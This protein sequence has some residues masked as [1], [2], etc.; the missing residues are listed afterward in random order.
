MTLITI[1]PGDIEE[2]HGSGVPAFARL[3]ANQQFTSSE[4]ILVA[5]GS[6]G[7]HRDFFQE[8]VAQPFEDKVHLSAGDAYSTTNSNVP[9]ATYS[10]VVYDAKGRILYTPYHNLRIPDENNPTTWA[11][12]EEFSKA[13]TLRYPPTYLNAEAQLRLFESFGREAGWGSVIGDITDQTDLMLVLQGITAGIEADLALKENADPDLTAIAQLAPTNDDILQRKGDVWTNRTPSQLKADLNLGYFSASDYDSLEDAIDDID[14]KPAELKITEETAVNVDVAIPATT[15]LSFAGE[16]MLVVEAGCTVTI[17]LMTDPGNKQIF[18]L[19]DA[20]ANIRFAN[21]AVERFN[22]AWWAGPGVGVD[23]TKAINDMIASSALQG[24]ICKFYFPQ[25]TSVT[26]GG[27]V[28]GSATRIFGNS[29]HSNAA[30]G[31][32][33]T[34]R[35]KPG[36]SAPFMFKIGP[37]KNNIDFSEI[38]LD[39]NGNATVCIL[40]EGSGSESAAIGTS[41]TRV[42]FSGF[43]KQVHHHST[44]GAWQ[45]AQVSFYRCQFG[46]FSGSAFAANS[47]NGQFHFN[48]CYFAPLPGAIDFDLAGAGIMGIENSEFAGSSYI[49]TFQ[50]ADIDVASNT[51]NK[52]AHGFTGNEPVVVISSGGLPGTAPAGE[53]STLCFIKYVD[54]SHIQFSKVAG[55][56]AIDLTSQGTGTHSIYWASAKVM[57]VTGAH[58]A[59]TFSNCQEE[60]HG[61]ML[62]N[63]ASDISGIFNFVNGC[64]IQSK[65]KSDASCQINIDRCNLFSYAVQGS[66][67]F[68][69]ITDCNIR[70]LSVNDGLTVVSPPV[71]SSGA[72]TVLSERNSI[73]GYHTLRIPQRDIST[74]LDV[75]NPAP[76]RSI[77]HIPNGSSTRK[78]LLR[79]GRMTN[80]EVFDFYYSLGRDNTNGRFFIE[81]NQAEPFRGFDFNADVRATQL[82]MS[83]SVA[84]ATTSPSVMAC[85]AANRFTITPNANVTIDTFE[86]VAGKHY[87]LT[88]LTAGVTSY[89]ITFGAGF[90]STGVLATGVVAGKYFVVE[91]FA[92]DATTLLELRRTAAL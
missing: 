50:P 35:L 64:L 58:G 33:T 6:R 37:T 42:T 14:D 30:V 89:D 52:P 43:T 29:Y 3:Y 54:P 16:G 79:L 83:T 20:T 73:L 69:N 26:E 12:L 36:T 38:I 46:L 53:F 19:E 61:A 72:I 66:A 92:P 13:V 2:Y 91:F 75:D 49:V 34:L 65:I 25:L 7:R 17:G 47:V 40:A 11:T 31:F 23:V 1:G 51:V 28:L 10:L 18:A 45:W 59:I 84:L 44:S 87:Y 82:S 48:D 71:V 41:F 74:A 81:G 15:L 4:G 24:G 39:A 22:A 63:T 90:K 21:G 77:G 56:S 60:G 57:R 27:H 86:I 76:V 80:A 8:F 70:P 55:G 67:G 88:V 62:E 85:R 68:A 5:Q 78:V 32:G 9:G